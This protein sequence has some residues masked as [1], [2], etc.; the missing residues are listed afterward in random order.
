MEME[1]ATR[2]CTLNSFEEANEYLKFGWK[3]LHIGQ[4]ARVNYNFEQEAH[5]VYT[6]GWCSENE[7]P[8]EPVK[9]TTSGFPKTIRL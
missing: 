2:I 9:D 3:L 8:K 4:Y 6:V 7:E 5:P 1:N